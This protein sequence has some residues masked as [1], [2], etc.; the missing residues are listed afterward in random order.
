MLEGSQEEV[1]WSPFM[2]LNQRPE[3]G[4]GKGVGK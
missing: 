2:S 4:A 1:F 3:L